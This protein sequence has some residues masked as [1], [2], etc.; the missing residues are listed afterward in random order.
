MCTELRRLLE[1]IPTLEPSEQKAK[2]EEVRESNGHSISVSDSDHLFHEWGTYNCFE[3]ALGLTKFQDYVI[4]KKKNVFA[5]S[6]FICYL[7]END[8][9]EES[10][11]EG[12]LIYF[13]GEAP[14]HAGQFQNNRVQSKWGSGLVFNH[15]AFE[16]PLSYGSTFKIYKDV[17]N[18]EM[19]EYFYDYA[20]TKG[21]RFSNG[22]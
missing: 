14:K 4:V 10:D 13:I 18:S 20:E 15:E 2:L 3:F 7:L 11:H 12:V 19:L 9:I 21:I 6:E 22:T 16:A 8:L 1:G 5:N 17:D